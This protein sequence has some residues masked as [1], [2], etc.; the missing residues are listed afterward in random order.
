MFRDSSTWSALRMSAFCRLSTMD[1]TKL[2]SPTT[3]SKLEKSLTAIN[4]TESSHSA[5]ISSSSREP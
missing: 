2:S 1:F 5:A 4:V 3:W